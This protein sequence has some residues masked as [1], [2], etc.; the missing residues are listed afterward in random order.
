M[1]AKETPLSHSRDFPPLR[2]GAD[3]SRVDEWIA[4]TQRV[5][6]RAPV[7]LSSRLCTYLHYLATLIVAEVVCSCSHFRFGP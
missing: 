6:S 2:S 5:C 7:I 1:D 4:S 3:L